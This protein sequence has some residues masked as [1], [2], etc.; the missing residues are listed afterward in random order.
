MP[1]PRPDFPDETRLADQFAGEMRASGGW[2]KGR[3]ASP[4]GFAVVGGTIGFLAAHGPGL[5]AAPVGAAIGYGVWSLALGRSAAGKARAVALEAWTG[6]RGLTAVETPPFAD[7]AL[8]RNG[9]RRS[10]GTGYQ[11]TIAGRDGI[12]FP[13]TYVS[14]ETRTRTTTDANGNTHTETYEVDVDHDYT[15]CR[16]ALPHATIPRLSLSQRGGLGFRFLD[17]IGSA[18]TSD[19]TVELESVEFDKRYRLEVADGSDDLAVRRLFTPVTIVWFTAHGPDS[20]ELENG[21][22][23]IPIP[24]RTDDPDTLE[25]LYETGEAVTEQLAAGLPH[26]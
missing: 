17:G 15:I 13:Y 18:L 22:L 3:I 21:A 26:V 5:V 6:A 7:T 16:V 4:A 9:Y 23:V 24:G 1:T 25:A 19:H 10:Y 11:G 12:I 2:R 14:R 20:L 8:L